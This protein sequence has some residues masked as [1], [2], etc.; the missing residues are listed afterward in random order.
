[1]GYVL[2]SFGLFSVPIATLLGRNARITPLLADDMY[3]KIASKYSKAN[4]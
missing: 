4:L 2:P 3:S 1:M